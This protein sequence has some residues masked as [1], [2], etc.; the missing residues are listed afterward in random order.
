LAINLF[1]IRSSN[2]G[3]LGRETKCHNPNVVVDRR[4]GLIFENRLAKSIHPSALLGTDCR[5]SPLSIGV[6][7]ELHFARHGG[8]RLGVSLFRHKRLLLIAPVQVV[9]TH[10]QHFR[11]HLDAVA[12]RADL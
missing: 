8:R 5:Y 12:Q 11:P 1:T 3:T 9:P 7:W 6:R 10:R 4:F 2:S